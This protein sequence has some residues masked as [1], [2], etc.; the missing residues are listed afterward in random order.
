ISY[1]GEVI[2]IGHFGSKN[3]MSAF[4]AFSAI[5]GISTWLMDSI[6]KPIKM[7]GAICAAL[8]ILV[9]YFAKS[10]GTNLTFFIMLAISITLYIYSNRN[11]SIINRSTLNSLLIG[12]FLLFTVTIYSTF[13][14]NY[15]EN[16][17]VS[18]GK[19]PTI[20]G[21]TIIWQ[22]GFYSIEDNPIFGVGY[23]AYWN[24]YNSGA[25]EIWER[26]HKEVGDPFGF[27]NTYINYYVELGI[28]GLLS[29]LMV[30]LSCIKHSYQ[31]VTHGMDP[32]DIAVFMLLLFY[33]SKSFFETSGF[34]PFSINH[35]SIC[36]IW[37]TLNRKT[38]FDCGKKTIIVFEGKE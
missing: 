38:F 16:L 8:S 27:H 11:F 31:R 29:I 15:Y 4:A 7:L 10:L 34:A 26:M 1:T 13:D 32:F 21:R 9:F 5:V 36:L 25:L 18:I 24:E 30:L 35:F 14:F 37:V 12:Y 2:R 20:T 6:P 3:S 19:D 17:M 33:L 28:L 22:I 23:D